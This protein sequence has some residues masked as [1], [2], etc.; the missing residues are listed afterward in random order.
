M[1]RLAPF[2][3]QPSPSTPRQTRGTACDRLASVL[4]SSKNKNKC[5]SFLWG[6]KRTTPISS[7]RLVWRREGHQSCAKVSHCW[8]THWAF[9]LDLSSCPEDEELHQHHKHSEGGLL[10]REV[11]YGPGYTASGPGGSL[12]S[13]AADT[14]LLMCL[15]SVMPAS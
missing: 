7:G 12:K 3:S 9:L 4:L 10:S 13:L 14:S 2:C 5:L 15:S 11:H 8:A 6:P 1:E